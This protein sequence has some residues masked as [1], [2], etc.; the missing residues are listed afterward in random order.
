M[1]EDFS[2][3][4]S[5]DSLKNVCYVLNDLVMPRKKIAYLPV[6]DWLFDI[7]DILDC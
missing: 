1:L 7:P 4:C 5:G 6:S 2:C 3:S